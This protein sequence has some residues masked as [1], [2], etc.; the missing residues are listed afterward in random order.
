MTVDLLYFAKLVF[1][2]SNLAKYKFI[3]RQ[4]WLKNDKFGKI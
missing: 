3:S 4:I 2:K 1:F